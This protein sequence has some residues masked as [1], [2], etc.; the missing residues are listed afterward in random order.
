[1]ITYH[2]KSIRIPTFGK[3]SFYLP[4]RYDSLTNRSSCLK[5]DYEMS[6]IWGYDIEVEAW[7]VVDAKISQD[8]AE[9]NEAYSECSYDS[10]REDFHSDG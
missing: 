3:R 2:V 7:E 9:E 8:E 5:R 10:D 1:M 4:M 6:S